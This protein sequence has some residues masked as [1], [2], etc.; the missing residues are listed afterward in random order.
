MFLVRDGVFFEDAITKVLVDEAASYPGCSGTR[1]LSDNL[2]DL[3]AQIAANTK[4]ANLVRS[5]IDECG[6]KKVSHNAFT[7]FYCSSFVTLNLI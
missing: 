3:K 2:N 4:G 1:S 6:I 5:L 7:T